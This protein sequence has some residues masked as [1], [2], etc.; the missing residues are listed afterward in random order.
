MVKVFVVQYKKYVVFVDGKNAY[1]RRLMEDSNG[2][3][4][5]YRN[6]KVRLSEDQL[7]Y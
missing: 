4:Y 7:Y 2:F 1:T 5:T 6:K 3:Y